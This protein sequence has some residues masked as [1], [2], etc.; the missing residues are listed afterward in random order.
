MS[1]SSHAVY[2]AKLSAVLDFITGEGLSFHKFVVGTLQ[3]NDAEIRKTTTK[4]IRSHA[5]TDPERY[6]P[7]VMLGAI[8][9]AVQSRGYHEQVDSFNSEL[10]AFSVPIFEA[11]FE[12]ASRLAFLHLP[13]HLDLKQATRQPQQADSHAQPFE[14]DFPRRV[15]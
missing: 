3:S 13:H 4:W 9:E 5:S 7:S 11:E 8:V 14:A 1:Q 2:Q 6:G 10:T 15:N 12:A